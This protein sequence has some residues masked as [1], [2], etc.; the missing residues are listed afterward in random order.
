[1]KSVYAILPAICLIAA[2]S[3][4]PKSG[5][6]LEHVGKEEII[7]TY[8]KDDSLK[9]AHSFKVDGG[10]VT[11]TA[12]ATISGD[13][14]RQEAA[15]KSAQLRAK[16]VLAQSISEKLN[17]YNQFA[18][19]GTGY[20]AS[21]LRELIEESSRLTANEFKLGHTY[22]ER[23]KIISD[24]GIPRTELRAWAAVHLDETAYKRLVLDSIR[25]QQGKATFSEQFAKTVDRN[26][27]KM[28]SEDEKAQVVTF[29]K[30]PEER[31]PTSDKKENE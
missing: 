30:Q 31:K 3:S 20:D 15:I 8:G 17:S 21:Q 13:S 29:D 5:I 7:Q 23:V 12:M 25:R 1:M 9:E 16:A 22:V 6:D 10:I 14:G 4:A 27:S 24:S 19:E 18:T 2:C 26:W 11:A 28:L